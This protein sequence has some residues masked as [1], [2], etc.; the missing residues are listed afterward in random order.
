MTKHCHFERSEKSV[1]ILNMKILPVWITNNNERPVADVPRPILFILIIALTMQ[2]T[3]QAAKPLLDPVAKPLPT[4]LATEQLHILS[5]GDPVAFAKML[6]LWLQAFDNQSGISIPFRE[7]DYNKVTGWLDNILKLDSKGQ[8]PLLAASRVY[9]QVPDEIRQR[10]MLEFV[11]EKFFN[12]PDRRWPSLAHAVYVAKHRLEDLP[13]ALRYAEALAENVTIEKAPFWVT[14]M[15]I[16]AL[17]D[18]DE[19]ESAKILLG[20][21]LESGAITDEHELWFLQERLKK[22]EEQA[23]E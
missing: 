16:Y 10:Q 14:Q 20:G 15:H 22:L 6:M 3:W 7:L 18:M 8:Y 17:E 12:D 2:I 19:I 5:L 23:K 9:S 13:L 21:L 1:V 4:P 11:Y